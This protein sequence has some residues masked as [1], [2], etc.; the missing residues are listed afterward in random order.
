MKVSYVF[1]AS[2][3][4]RCRSRGNRVRAPWEV[5]LFLVVCG[6]V[7]PG[8]LFAVPGISYV[9]LPTLSEST[10]EAPWAKGFIRLSVLTVG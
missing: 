10:F 6:P 1:F 5:W 8:V 2:E 7:T 3:S 4:N 9:D